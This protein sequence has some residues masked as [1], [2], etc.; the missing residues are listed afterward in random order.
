MNPVK[1]Y[2]EACVENRD[3]ILQVLKTV[4]QNARTV[5]EIGSGTGQHAA[6][7]PRY[8]THLH[9]Q[10]SDRMENIAGIELWRKEAGLANVAQTIELDVTLHWPE[11]QYDAVFS[12]N[13]AH[14]M[15]WP[16]VQK[17][18]EGIADCLQTPG[19]FCLYGP[20]KQDGQHNAESNARFDSFLRQR[21]PD[22]GVRD[23]NDIQ[24]AAEQL[25]LHFQEMIEM[26]VNNRILLFRR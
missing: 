21:D 12:A 18:L 14:I 15:S 10:P 17:M 7:F 22:S 25:G 1:P 26:P 23:L 6:Y 19:V 11:Q 3:P 8:L 4:F 9:W 2:S 20:F 16:A 5:L 13:T 24:T